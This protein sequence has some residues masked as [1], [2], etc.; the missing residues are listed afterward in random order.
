MELK[1]FIE[2][3]LK[4]WTGNQPEVLLNYYSEDAFYADPAFPEGIKGEELLR[5]YFTKLLAKNPTWVWEVVEIFPTE[6]GCTLKWKAN[7]PSGKQ[8]IQLTGLDIVEIQ[9]NKITRNEVFFDRVPWLKAIG[10]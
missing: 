8:I 5:N 7:I 10:K 1:Q 4:A 2:N 6:K 3:W 9:N